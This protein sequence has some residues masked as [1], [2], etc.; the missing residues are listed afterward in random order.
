MKPSSRT[1]A[2]LALAALIS[3]TALPQRA[4][5]AGALAPGTDAPPFAL[6]RDTSG[7]L[8]FASVRGRPIY[9]NF[10][11][12]WCGPCIQEAPS[13]AR[14]TTKYQPHGL[15]TIGI[16]ELEDASK[17]IDFS[18][19]YRLPYVVLVDP[20]GQTGK[21]YGALGL[22]VHV[23]IARNGKISTYRLGEMN[24]TEIE[25]AIKKIIAP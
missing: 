11:A 15:M 6:K 20:D 1:L 18:N 21:D 4:V 10:F 13:I 25:A 3:T 17:G 8:T 2:M 19:R 24:P 16:D 22:P 7:T 12:S 9:L 23:F 5:A 14:L